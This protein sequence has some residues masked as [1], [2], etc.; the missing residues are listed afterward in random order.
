MSRKHRILFIVISS[1]VVTMTS[2]PSFA[3][4]VTPAPTLSPAQQYE[5]DLIKYKIEYRIYEDARDLREKELRA[6]AIA[7]NQALRQANEDARNAGRGAASKAAFAAARALAAANR[8]KAIAELPPL[9]NPPQP[10][11]KPKGFVSKGNKS[12]ESSPRSDRKN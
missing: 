1:L 3:A 4:E 6:I 5:L 7:F 10:P 12:K 9:M 11:I 8:D 2:S